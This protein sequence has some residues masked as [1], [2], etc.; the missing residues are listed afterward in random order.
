MYL[1]TEH[2][3]HIQRTCVPCTKLLLNTNMI[4]LHFATLSSTQNTLITGT[5]TGENTKDNEF[6][7]MIHSGKT[8][9]AINFDEAGWKLAA[10]YFLHPILDHGSLSKTSVTVSWWAPI[11]LVTRNANFPRFSAFLMFW[12]SVILVARTL[13]V[14]FAPKFGKV[15]VWLQF[16]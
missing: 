5:D 3:K 15:A 11:I 14:A 10:H 13:V 12:C 8:F 4:M 7:N 6:S 2:S 16:E 1:Y 9:T